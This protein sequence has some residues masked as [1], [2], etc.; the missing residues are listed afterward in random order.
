MALT[1]EGKF[2]T[3]KLLFDNNGCDRFYISNKFVKISEPKWITSTEIPYIVVLE[4][5]D[6]GRVNREMYMKLDC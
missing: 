6:R 3:A 5:M 1:R 2:F 4:D